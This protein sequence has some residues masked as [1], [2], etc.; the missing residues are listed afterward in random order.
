MIE[1]RHGQV[2]FNCFRTR[3]GTPVVQ[4]RFGPLSTGEFEDIT[5]NTDVVALGWGWDGD[6]ERW[7]LALLILS[8]A[9]GVEMAAAH[10][11]AFAS[12]LTSQPDDGFVIT[13]DDLR[14]WVGSRV[15]LHTDEVP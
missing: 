10:V 2:W 15:P 12:W 9:V 3:E 5:R 13:A 4:K 14:G 8:H 7:N 11:S 6:P 1:P